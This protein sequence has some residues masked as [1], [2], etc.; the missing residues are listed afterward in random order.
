MSLITLDDNRLS[1]DITSPQNLILS[2]C[3]LIC[4][5][6]YRRF[7]NVINYEQQSKERSSTSIVLDFLI[8]IGNNRHV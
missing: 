7:P 2:M 6:N 1:P 3:G 4:L 5:W 8:V